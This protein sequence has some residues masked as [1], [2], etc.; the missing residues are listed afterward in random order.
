MT[1]H[2]LIRWSIPGYMFFLAVVGFFFVQRVIEGELIRDILQSPPMTDIDTASA[3]LL[4]LSGIPFGFALQQGYYW[5]YW[6][7]PLLG[8]AP[9]DRGRQMLRGLD[10]PY[11]KLGLRRPYKIRW[12]DWPLDG[13]R[14]IFLF[15]VVR[16]LGLRKLQATSRRRRQAMARQY[17]ANWQEANLIW[18]AYLHWLD[19]SQFLVQQN[20]AHLLDVFHALGTARLAVFL[21]G[22]FYL[23]YALFSDLSSLVWQDAIAFPLNIALGTAVILTFQGARESA[24]RQVILYV[25]MTLSHCLQLERQKSAQP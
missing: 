13:W 6:N 16:G 12:S 4:G 5:M 17:E 9:L 24:L 21:A 10:I 3:I 7:A 22:V 8:I 1:T 2:A 15:P 19:E 14:K 18:S 11:A 25:Q 20:T 23:V